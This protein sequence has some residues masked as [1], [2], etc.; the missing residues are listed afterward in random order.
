M[1]NFNMKQGLTQKDLNFCN[2]YTQ[3]DES[4]IKE[5][6]KRFRKDCPSGAYTQA[7][8]VDMYKVFFPCG[9]AYKFSDHI[10]RALDADK[11]GLIDFKK[12]ILVLDI[13]G[14]GRVDEK[15]RFAFKMYDVNG[16]GLIDQG[17]MI[18]V[19][20]TLYELMGKNNRKKVHE[21]AEKRT[22]A[23]FAEMDRNKDGYLTQDEFFCGCQGDNELS[24]ILRFVDFNKPLYR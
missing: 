2:T 13:M 11:S 18:Q 1:G 17:E 20:K 5:L 15:L 22:K 6:H 10:L 24:N 12:F 19:L 9:N 21:A 8:M 14:P 4:S 23:V 3:F 7:D 16:N